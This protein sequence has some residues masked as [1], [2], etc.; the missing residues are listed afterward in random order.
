MRDLD[1]RGGLI[2]I[3]GHA[4]EENRRKAWLVVWDGPPFIIGSQSLVISW[5]EE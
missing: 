1:K 2:A 5:R 3:K 4:P